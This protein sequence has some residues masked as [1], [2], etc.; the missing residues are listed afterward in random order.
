MMNKFSFDNVFDLVNSLPQSVK[1][2]K[3]SIIMPFYN[4]E[5]LIVSS[6]NKVVESL[7]DW[8]WNFEVIVSDDGST[9]NSLLEL[10]KIAHIPELKVISSPSNYGKG[11]ALATAY[12]ISSGEYILFLDSDLELPIEH[13]PYF[14]K[15]ML[16]EDADVVIGSKK[17]PRSNI[18]YPLFRKLTSFI[19]ALIVK[20]LFRLPVTDTQTGIKLFKREAL[21][22]SLP[23]LLVKKFAFD[24]ELLAL[25]HHKGFKIVGHPIVLVF[26]R[27]QAFGRISIDSILHMIKDTMAI[28][29]RFL[30]KFWNL[31]TFAKSSLKQLVV[32]LD[33]D[34]VCF[35][36]NILAINSLTELVQFTKQIS[37]YDIVIFLNKGQELPIFTK[38]SVNRIFSDPRIDVVYPLIY[39][40]TETSRSFLYYNLLAN[41]FFAK[42]YYPRYRPVRQGF[43]DKDYTSSLPIEKTVIRTSLLL[44]LISAGE[45]CLTDLQKTVHT[46]YIFLHHDI[47]TTSNEWHDYLKSV[48]KPMGVKKWV[49]I[50]TISVWMLALGGYC[51]NFLFAPAIFL[52]ISIV[53]WFI[54][55]LGIRRGVKLAFIFTLNRFK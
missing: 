7:R 48:E 38:F 25:I 35:E 29:W 12:E 19:Y 8:S 17:D 39:S 45:L 6:V 22:K 23:Y 47:A 32:I 50:T 15:E 14:F 3:L 33:K 16:A 54:F 42:G 1:Q 9:D 4:E 40:K 37:Q 36:E 27:D 52:E 26:V 30:T 21:E 24:I 34:V 44:D 10:Q 49:K 2:Q 31:Q 55:S 11:R 5:E 13:L 43:L 46:P 53:F 20:I 41:V 18:D 51:Q 28:V